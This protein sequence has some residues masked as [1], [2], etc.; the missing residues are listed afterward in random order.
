MNAEQID[1]FGFEFVNHGFNSV[2]LD[3]CMAALSNWALWK[4]IVIG[5]G[6]MVLLFGGFK[7]RAFVFCAFLALLIADNCVANTL[8]I[9]TNRPRPNQ[10]ERQV[11]I[12]RLEKTSPRFVG[13]IRRPIVSLSTLSSARRGSSSFPS[14]HVTNN[15]AFAAL[16]TWF[17]RRWGWT[18]Y[19]VATLIGYSRVYVGDHYPSDVLAGAMIGTGVAMVVIAVLEFGWRKY[20]ARFLPAIREV[21]PSL[22]R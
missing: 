15:F 3:V 16:L 21:H 10:T 11:R 14:T 22:A 17:Y 9:L 19:V 4:P 20:G 18:Y 7:G 13:L 12:V 2:V 5:L 1:Q 6:A 8:K